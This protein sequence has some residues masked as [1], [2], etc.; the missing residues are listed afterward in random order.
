M[1][2]WEVH[3]RYPDVP[4]GMTIRGHT[5]ES[6]ATTKLACIA[7][8]RK[9][10]DFYDLVKLLDAGIDLHQVW[11]GYV[12]H[13]DRLRA[14]GYQQPDPIQTSNG[15]HGALR[16]LNE[17]WEELR[18][19]GLIPNAPEFADISERVD[20]AIAAPLQAWLDVLTP[21]ELRDRRAAPANLERADSPPGLTR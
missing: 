1:G 21:D 13:V 4:S 3:T 16:M 12:A 7:R 20:R 11:P 17:Q 6:V 14:L 5:L 18:P 2:L 9:S 10:R 15:Y 19:T 8:R